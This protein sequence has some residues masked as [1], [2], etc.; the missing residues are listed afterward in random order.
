MKHWVVIV[1]SERRT[2][3]SRLA[4]AAIVLSAVAFG[5]SSCAG[6]AGP[7]QHADP[8][9]VARA[10][11][12]AHAEPAPPG[13]SVLAGAPDTVA[14]GVARALFSSA[15]VVVVT[16]TDH[17]ADV[18]AGVARAERA[19]A[20]L[21]LATGTTVGAATRTEIGSLHPSAVLAVGVAR[22]TVAAQL[23]GT[24]VVTRPAA[25]PSTSALPSLG[26]MVV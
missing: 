15:P 21:L 19:H 20:P 8:P 3:L 16:D 2:G 13:T 25:L 18:S 12:A 24:R 23:P 26:H 9:P 6:A 11:L 22:R 5:T 1:L 17:S 4:G 10:P 14:A 7:P